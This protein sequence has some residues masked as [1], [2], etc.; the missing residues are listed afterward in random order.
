MPSATYDR[1]AL[2]YDWGMRWLE[3]WFLAGLR[4]KAFDELPANSRILEIGAG[5]G[6]NFRYYQSEAFGVATELSTEMIRMAASKS[7]PQTLA[8]IQNCAEAI[9]FADASF[10]AALATL[11][12]CSLESPQRALTELKRVLKPGGTLVLIEH[13]RPPGLL[14]YVFDVL[15]RITVPLFEDHLNRR[16][17]ETVRGA[18]FELRRVERRVA[19]IINLITCIR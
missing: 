8:L 3:R 12:F 5:T 14:G 13:V 9:P 17:A 6:A 15:N 18:G 2:H 4:R 11:V 16:T 7:R 10:D 19:G 1:I